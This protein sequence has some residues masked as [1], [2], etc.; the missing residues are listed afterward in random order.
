MIVRRSK[1]GELD[2]LPRGTACK[3]IH[4]NSEQFEIWVQLA[5]EDL[6][7]RWELVGSYNQLTPEYIIKKELADK[8]LCK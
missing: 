1:P 6:V 3:V 7:P 2:E 5:Q 8:K 4:E